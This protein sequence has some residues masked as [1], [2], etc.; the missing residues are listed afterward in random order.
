MEADYLASGYGQ[1]GTPKN[2]WDLLTFA[3]ESNVDKKPAPSILKGRDLI[4]LGMQ[5]GPA[6]GSILKEAYEAQLEEYFFDYDGAVEWVTL[7]IKEPL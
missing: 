2:A 6:I 1:H 3:R 7:Q 5:E 4:G